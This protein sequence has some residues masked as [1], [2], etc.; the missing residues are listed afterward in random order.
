MIKINT[1]VKTVALISAIF[2]FLSIVYIVINLSSIKPKKLEIVS[3]TPLPN[4]TQVNFSKTIKIE[5]K[6]EPEY[7]DLL[8]LKNEPKI[9]FE[10]KID[11]QFLIFKPLHFY[12]PLTIYQFTLSQKGIQEPL[13]SWSFKTKSSQS[14]QNIY[15]KIEDYNQDYYPLL[16]YMPIKTKDF[17]ILYTNKKALK[18]I[19]YS[20]NVSQVKKDVKNLIKSKGV[21]PETHQFRWVEINK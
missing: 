17:E 16:Q 6:G 2:I 8:S 18:V 5:L 19:I 3:I 7:F 15:Q 11:G 20:L 4:S 21:K 13:A 14:N 1:S 9:E 10:K 12:S